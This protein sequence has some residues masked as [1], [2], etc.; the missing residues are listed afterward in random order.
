MKFPTLAEAHATSMEFVMEPHFYT[1][2]RET[3]HP[4]FPHL[5]RLTLIDC[6]LSTLETLFNERKK[7]SR[8][9]RERGK[10]AGNGDPNDLPPV[11]VP[12]R[13]RL[14]RYLNVTGNKLLSLRGIEVFPGLE[15]LHACANHIDSMQIVPAAAHSESV[16]GD[17]ERRNRRRRHGSKIQRP[18]LL[19]R[20]PRLSCL[21][22]NKALK[23]VSLSQNQL[24]SM[25]G[26][27][28]LRDLRVLNLGRNKLREAR[29]DDLRV[30]QCSF[31]SCPR[32]E[33][34]ND[35][36]PLAEAEGSTRYCAKCCEL[37]RERIPMGMLNLEILNLAGNLIS[38]FLLKR[39]P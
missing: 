27:A 3:L 24:R 21:Y 28:H 39:C 36:S 38:S 22:A 30:I 31:S 4:C 17:K 35:L 1:C 8:W 14:L 9:Q 16:D 29:E 25:R 26:F 13:Y 15:E 19:K 7:R 33:G 23:I 18:T 32:C 11:E 12:V 37:S 2:A 6:G 5:L 34:Q 10:K 20:K